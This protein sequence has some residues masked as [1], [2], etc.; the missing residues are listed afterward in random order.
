MN[1]ATGMASDETT[2]HTGRLLRITHVHAHTSGT[3]SGRLAEEVDL[4]K[5][6]KPVCN[7]QLV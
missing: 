3:E 1:S 2:A 7:A 4:C 5:Y 6:W